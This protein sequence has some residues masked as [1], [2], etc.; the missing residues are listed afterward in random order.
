MVVEKCESAINATNSVLSIGFEFY[1]CVD[2]AAMV[3]INDSIDGVMA[4]VFVPGT[5]DMRSAYRE[6]EQLQ[7]I[8]TVT[9]SM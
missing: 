8:R 4:E 2:E 6:R 9:D 1:G 5:S 7:C 3:S